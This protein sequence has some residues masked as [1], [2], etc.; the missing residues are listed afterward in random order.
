MHQQISF[1]SFLSR[2]E[3]KSDISPKELEDIVIDIFAHIRTNTERGSWVEI[4]G[5]GSFHPLW[6]EIKKLKK[7]K[8]TSVAK[9]LFIGS[10]FLAIIFTLLM[11][12]DAIKPATKN[13][14]AILAESTKRQYNSFTD[15]EQNGTIT[16]EKFYEYTVVKG[17]NLYT[18]S[19]MLYGDS[20]FWPLIYA[21]NMSNIKDMDTIYPN[22]VLKIPRISKESSAQKELT[23]V[24]IQAYKAYK[25]L[26]K[27]NKAHWLLYWGRQNIDCDLLDTYSGDIASDDSKIVREYI[28]R[29]DAKE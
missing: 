6:Y 19:E 3:L 14:Q 10:A 16:A 21:E 2:L 11:V 22:N 4:G 17:E 25:S 8:K 28:E 20:K 1:E 5:F 13:S 24:Y 18:I 27:D 23:S 9:Y 29:F 12:K 26:G 15:I 7:R